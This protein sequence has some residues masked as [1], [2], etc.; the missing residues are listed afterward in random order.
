MKTS[1][2]KQVFQNAEI[3]LP[4]MS[5]G[6]YFLQVSDNTDYNRTVKFFN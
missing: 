4:S 2:K 6:M 3:Q 1:Q 5:G